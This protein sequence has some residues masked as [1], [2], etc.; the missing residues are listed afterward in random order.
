LRGLAVGIVAPSSI[1][2]GPRQEAAGHGPPA[3]ALDNLALIVGL[4]LLAFLADSAHC[5]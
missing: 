3:R 5:R 2:A 4:P 1:R